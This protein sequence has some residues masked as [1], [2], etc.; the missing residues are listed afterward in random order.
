MSDDLKFTGV[1]GE[2]QIN[3]VWHDAAPL[4][5]RAIDVYN[6]HSLDE[7]YSSLLDGSRQLWVCG[8]KAIES[9]LITQLINKPHE[10][11]CFLELCAGRGVESTKFLNIIEE[12]AKQAGCTRMELSG[13]AGWKR[14]LKDY[15][16]KKIILSKELQNAEEN[17]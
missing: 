12:W 1:I 10:K 5:L 3:A 15:N 7:I 9:I 17:Q 13:R 6:E 4:I 8:N 16:L 14:K 11:V 2:E